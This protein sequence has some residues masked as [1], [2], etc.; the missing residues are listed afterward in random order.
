MIFAFFMRHFSCYNG[1]YTLM[2]TDS[3]IFARA[4][5]ENLMKPHVPLSVGR[6]NVTYNGAICDT[7]Y[8]STDFEP[9]ICKS[10]VLYRQYRRGHPAFIIADSCGGDAGP[11]RRWLYARLVA[12]R[13]NKDAPGSTVPS[14]PT[15]SRAARSQ[16]CSILTELV[17]LRCT[18]GL[19]EILQNRPPSGQKFAQ[20]ILDE[21][22]RTPTPLFSPHGNVKIEPD[23][24]L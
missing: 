20:S 14:E 3:P 23:A 19:N 8:N 22:W 21:I 16:L 1:P 2:E 17:S 12:S 13:Y 5:I 11:R 6:E 15:G 9:R 7:F 24:S 4:V 18:V 10:V